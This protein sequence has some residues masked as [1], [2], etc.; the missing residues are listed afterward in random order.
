MP[1]KPKYEYDIKKIEDGCN[2]KPRL[3]IRAVARAN[4]WP[5]ASTCHWV[6]RNYSRITKYVEKTKRC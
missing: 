5:E 4:N 1:T 3:S 6:K 2:S